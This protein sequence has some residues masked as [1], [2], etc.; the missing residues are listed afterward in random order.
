MHLLP[1]VTTAIPQL[2][3]KP[4]PPAPAPPPIPPTQLIAS[5]RACT[6]TTTAAPQQPSP[7]VTHQPTSAIQTHSSFL[8]P[9]IGGGMTSFGLANPLQA[10]QNILPG[11]QH[12]AT[13]PTPL[14]C[15]TQLQPLAYSTLNVSVASTPTRPALPPA[16][17]HMAGMPT[18]P[19]GVMM[20]NKI[21][22]PGT[23]TTGAMS[24]YQYQQ[25]A[26]VAGF[27]Q[28]SQTRLTPLL[29]TVGTTPQGMNLLLPPAKR[30]ALDPAY[31]VVQ[32]PVLSTPPRSSLTQPNRIPTTLMSP[33]VTIT[34]GGASGLSLPQLAPTIPTTQPRTQTPL[35]GGVGLHSLTSQL[36]GQQHH[37]YNPMG[38]TGWGR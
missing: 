38:G 28:S 30:P 5:G 15:I 26:A 14:P 18:L 36:P 9:G 37:G 35:G 1:P 11:T 12:P 33:Q 20:P 29:G 19:S 17:Y 2:M 27:H 13:Q 23:S 10:L 6:P 7:S 8:N 24:Q 21:L 22:L 34:Q 31:R 32:S 16:G 3:Q 4:P 25:Q